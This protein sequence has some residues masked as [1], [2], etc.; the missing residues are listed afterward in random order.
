VITI[1]R[2]D[3]D[4]LLELARRT[5]ELG[6]VSVYAHA[7]PGQDPGLE[8]VGID[9]KNRYRELERRMSEDGAGERGREVSTALERLRPQLEALTDPTAPGRGRIVFAGLGGDW[10]LDL[11]SAM[12]VPNRV[13]LDAD[14]FIH[15]LLELLDEGQ[16][17]GVVLVSPEEA[18]LLEWRLGRL[19]PLARMEPAEVEAPH[20]RAGQIGGGPVGQFHTPMREHRQ[21][22]QR[23]RAERFLDRVVA[24]AT[25]LAGARRW[26]RLLVSG[27]DRWTEHV[28]ASFPDHLRDAVLRDPRVL[29]G[30]DDA[31]LADAVSER[32]HE[33]HAAR[34]RRLVERIR[35]A[36]HAQ[37]GALGLSEVTAALN[38]GRVA[39]LV[40]DPEIR[41][42]GSVGD[43]GALYAGDEAAPDGGTG[44]PDTRLTERLVERALATGARVSPVEGAARGVLED[45]AGVAAL[46]RW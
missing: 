15:P 18:R 23:D 25:E 30:L 2:F 10:L 8:G 22:R 5:D 32:M 40:Y 20:E 31:G 33:E 35:D 14:P 3:E 16:P 44:T 39:H 24:A 17:A 4:A 29:G 46:R 21:A 6:V 41:Y 42:T 7:D 27:G 12:P 43:G 36:A 19:R 13:V 28:A 38:A 37:R 34:E 45:A 9:L 1:E 26:A 11:R